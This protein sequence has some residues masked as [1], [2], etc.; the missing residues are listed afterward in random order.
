MVGPDETLVQQFR[1]R[2]CLSIDRLQLEHHH[3]FFHPRC[4]FP[5]FL[6]APFTAGSRKLARDVWSAHVYIHAV[7]G[8]AQY[9]HSLDKKAY[10]ALTHTH[11]HSTNTQGGCRSQWPFV[12][13]RGSA[14]PR[15]L[16]HSYRQ[17]APCIII[18][19]SVSAACVHLSRNPRTL[20]SLNRTLHDRRAIRRGDELRS[21]KEH[22]ISPM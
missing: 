14:A 2:G 1:V 20:K 19:S 22:H 18:P 15:S 16:L 11:T 13:A 7:D 9:S 8:H 5:C 4:S 12:I 6:P 17:V 10:F 21:T 3:I